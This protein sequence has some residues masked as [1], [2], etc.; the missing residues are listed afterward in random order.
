L[1]AA[2]VELLIAGVD[3]PNLVVL[4]GE[5][6]ADLD[7]VA[8]YLG[9]TLRDLGLRPLDQ[10]S[11][12]LRTIDHAAQEILDGR[13]APRDGAAAIWDAYYPAGS[14][15]GPDVSR[16]A[17]IADYLDHGWETWGPSTAD[18]LDA[19]RTYVAGKAVGDW[20]PASRAFRS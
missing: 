6:S 7:E 5:D 14:K 18:F 13:L 20:D 17:T 16:L 3:S 19:V 8:E 4:A 9:A 11:I 1:V 12:A 2:A 10:V 15:L